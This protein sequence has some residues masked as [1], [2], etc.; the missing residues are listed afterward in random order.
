MKSEAYLLP[1]LNRKLE[2]TNQGDF[3]SMSVEENVKHATAVAFGS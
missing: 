2:D 1:C 3:H